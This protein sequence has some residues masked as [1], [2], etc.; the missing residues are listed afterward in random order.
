[1][2]RLV[3]AVSLVS[4]L[5]M[6]SFAALPPVYQRMAELR[7]VLDAVQALL[8]EIGE[9][10]A[11]EF[12]AVDLYEVR[13]DR[14]RVAAHIVDTPQAGPPIVGPRQFTIVLDKAVCTAR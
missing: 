8:E 4:L 12:I 2:K 11:V 10:T 7:A 14:C 9:V 1:M 6:P 3:L 13:S 5:A